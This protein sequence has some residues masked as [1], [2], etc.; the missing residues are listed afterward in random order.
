MTLPALSLRGLR[1]ASTSSPVFFSFS[2]GDI[3][4]GNDADEPA[5]LDKAQSSNLVAGYESERLLEV[6]VRLNADH[7]IAGVVYPRF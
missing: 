1:D 3:G 5:V 6:F 7:R 4:L 2:Q